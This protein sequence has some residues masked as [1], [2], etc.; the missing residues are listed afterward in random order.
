MAKIRSVYMPETTTPTLKS[1]TKHFQQ[2]GLSEKVGYR[3][4]ARRYPNYSS[5]A[6][7]PLVEVA[8]DYLGENAYVHFI[9]TIGYPQFAEAARDD[10]KDEHGDKK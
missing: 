7:D 10:W 2:F 6:K 9:E 3:N 5:L 8:F 4:K 1:L